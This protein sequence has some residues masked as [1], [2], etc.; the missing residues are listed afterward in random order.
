VVLRE[1]SILDVIDL[2]LRFLVA[3]KRAYAKLA[4]LVLVPA[5]AASWA[6][7]SMA[8]WA[9][10]WIG[11][12][13]VAMV[14]EVPF[15]VLASRLVFA[16]EVRVGHVLAAAL[17]V[18]PR[19]VVVKA[20]HATM[21]AVS[22]TVLGAAAFWVGPI[23][24]FVSEVVVLEQGGIGGAFGR[25]QRLVNTQFGEGFL[26]WILLGLAP[27]LAAVVG[28][29]VGRAAVEEGLQFRPP[30]SLWDAGGSWL[31]LVGFW[32]F[33]PAGATARFF[34]YLNLRTRSEGWD[35]QTRFAAIAARA[36]E[37]GGP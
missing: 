28:D 10:G 26:G 13:A 16:E 29:L 19:L 31:A 24:L 2:A 21:L 11:A 6:F 5:F 4:V 9:W 30:P 35:I 32:L 36:H 14:A 7:A 33:V 18:M 12:L 1:R 34:L 23:T 27:A 8:G 37:A 22:G 25:S 3:E 20:L 15:T 17:R